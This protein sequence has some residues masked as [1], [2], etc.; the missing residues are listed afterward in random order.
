VLEGVG[1]LLNPMAPKIPPHSMAIAQLN[2][3]A[4]TNSI[5]DVSVVFIDNRRY[6]MGDL[7]M[8][9]QR[10]VTLE[11]YYMN[12]YEEEFAKTPIVN[13]NGERLTTI[14]FGVDNVNTAVVNVNDVEFKAYYDVGTGKIEPP[15]VSSYMDFVF[16]STTGYKDPLTGVV[17]AH[18]NEVLYITQN[19]A[20]SY[21]SVNFYITHTWRG[22][23]SL[24]PSQ[25]SWADIENVGNTVTI[26]NSGGSSNRTST[27][28]VTTTTGAQVSVPWIRSKEVQYSVTGVK[29]FAKLNLFFDGK[30]ISSFVTNGPIICDSKGSAVGTFTI[31]NTSALRF[32]VGTKTVIVTEADNPVDIGIDNSL[33]TAMYSANGTLQTNITTTTW[34]ITAVPPPVRNSDPLSQ[35]FFV[36]EVGG[37]NISSV[38]VYFYKKASNLP[39]TLELRSTVNGYPSSTEVLA[40]STKTPA[41]VNVSTN[42]TSPTNFKFSTPVYLPE[43]EYA[44]VVKAD[45]P[46]YYLWR[47]IIGQSDVITNQMISSQPMLGSMFASQNGTAWTAWQDSDMK[48]TLR[49][50]NFMAS[51]EFNVILKCNNNAI[52]EYSKILMQHLEISK[53]A[54]SNIRYSWIAANAQNATTPLDIL[55]GVEKD[56][57]SSIYT[58][59]PTRNDAT[60]LKITFSTNTTFNSPSIDTSNVSA[61]VTKSN[62]SRKV[63][64]LIPETH[65]LA[66]SAAAKYI[67]QT[68]NIPIDFDASHLKIHARGYM[69]ASTSIE[70]YAKFRNSTDS[71]SMELKNWTLLPITKTTIVD[72]VEG[73]RHYLEA[74]VSDLVYVYN[75]VEYTGFKSFMIKVVMWSTDGTSSPFIE[76]IGYQAAL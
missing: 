41:N 67:S 69:P 26:D 30:D 1:D 50:A 15:R 48:F 5:D 14:G 23:M 68:L 52:R 19:K 60:R 13:A 71:S 45:S 12:K 72:T 20:S 37:V 70:I 22:N 46:D 58:F 27:S 75:S 43:G 34:T 42:A 32:A 33:A 49:K 63:D 24:V 57:G 73:P 7:R 54:N 36:E 18:Y 44:I 47:A 61:L 35:T 40:Y 64:A 65:P 29:P 4:G 25:D 31:P 17:C 3:G 2:L 16:D 53:D 28:R 38:D 62:I 74:L 11:H 21:V 39:V 76:L 10:I 59:N 51:T 6:T 8:M 55:P 9:D 66:G 56:T